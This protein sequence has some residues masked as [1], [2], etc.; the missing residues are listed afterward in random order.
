M[1]WFPGWCSTSSRT[2]RPRLAEMKRVSAKGGVIGAYVWD[3]AGKMELMR[4]LWDA[5]VALDAGRSR[6]D[7]GLRFPLCRPD[8]LAGLFADAKLEQV[9]VTAIDIATPFASFED[10]WQ[11]FLGGQGSAPA[12]VMSLDESARRLLR[13]TVKAR[14]PVLADGSLSMSARAWV[15]QG[16]V[17][18]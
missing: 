7:E 5:V 1:R 15:V 16:R 2:R 14:L 17:A 18:A 4:Y 6:F 11:P 10:Y 12:Y 9:Q 8:A 13:D 3:Y